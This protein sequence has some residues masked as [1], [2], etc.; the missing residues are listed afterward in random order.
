MG[1]LGFIE[2]YMSADQNIPNKNEDQNG[3]PKP[4]DSK[5]QPQLETSNMET[6]AQHLHKAPGGGWS[7]YLFEFLML[8]LAVFCGFL[9]ENQREHMVERRREKDYITGM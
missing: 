3:E 4:R 5:P 6:H 8:F 7:H 1:K 9:A 2:R